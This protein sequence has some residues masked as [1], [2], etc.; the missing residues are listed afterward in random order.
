M[1]SLSH[2]EILDTLRMIEQ[3]K[4]DI[5]TIT[6]GI[7]LLDCACATRRRPPGGV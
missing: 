2:H 5:R 6:L 7:S 4:L 3:E 1:P